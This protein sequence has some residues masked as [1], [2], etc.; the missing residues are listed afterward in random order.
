MQQ[1]TKCRLCGEPDETINN[2]VRE[3]SKFAQKEYKTK[4]D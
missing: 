2:F 3:D 4:H 1:S